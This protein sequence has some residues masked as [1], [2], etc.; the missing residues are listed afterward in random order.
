M[1]KSNPICFKVIFIH[2]GTHKTGTKS[3]QRWLADE[4]GRLAL[5]GIWF[6]EGHHSNPNNHAE[7]GLAALREDRDSFAR[8]AHPAKAG[9][10]Y[11]KL[12]QQ[13]VQHYLALHDSCHFIFSNEDLSYLRHSDEVS[14]LKNIFGQREIKIVVC[15]RNK[16]DFL[17]SYTSQISKV[18]ERTPSN[19]RNSCL[20]VESDS[21][22][23]DY[24][25]LVS[26][27]SSVFGRQ[28]IFIVDYDEAV[29]K[30]GTVLH[31]MLAALG[32]GDSKRVSVNNRYFLNES[33]N[34]IL[35]SVS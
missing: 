32:I 21:W 13:Q 16:Q 3:L 34:K 18:P 35:K 25:A 24:D 28:N 1:F 19:D 26:A 11:A 12:V 15:L 29:R 6:Y 9:F 33:A 2:I 10:A 17:R 20:Y 8:M 7:L 31:S 22:L 30:E 5:S 27:Y 23:L 4:R 14:V